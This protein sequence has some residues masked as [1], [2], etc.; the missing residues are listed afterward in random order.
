[1]ANK[2]KIKLIQC[3]TLLVGEN[4]SKTASKSYKKERKKVASHL[5]KHMMKTGRSGDYG[6]SITR[7]ARQ[8]QGNGHTK[9]VIFIAKLM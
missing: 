3:K 4:L 1:M 6:S 9:D 2:M 7:L 5:I 8:V